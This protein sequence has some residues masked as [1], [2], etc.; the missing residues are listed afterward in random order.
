MHYLLAL[1][2]PY[3]PLQALTRRSWESLNALHQLLGRVVTLFFCLHTAFYLNFF[4]RANLLAKRIREADVIL[5]LFAITS[6]TIIGTTALTWVRRRNYRLFYAVHVVLATMLLPVL[7]FHVTHIRIYIWE[8]LAV[9]VLHFVFRVFNERTVAV[10]MALVPGTKDLL[11][12][13]IPLPSSSSSAGEGK[14]W[15][16]TWQPGQHVYLSLQRTGLWTRPI[17]SKNPFTIASLPTEDGTLKLVARMMDGNTAAL[18][19]EAGD[20]GASR[21]ASTSLTIEGPYGLTTHS[22]SLLGYSRVLFVAGGV[23]ATFIVPLYRCL[24]RDL[25]PSAGSRRRQNVKFVWAVREVSETTWAM[26]DDSGEAKG[27]RER[28]SVFVTRGTGAARMVGQSADRGDDEA[29]DAPGYVKTEGADDMEDGVEM[30][31]LLPSGDDDE[32]ISAV[33]D[34]K[35]VNVEMGRPDVRALVNETLAGLTDSDKVA[36]VVCGPRGLARSVRSEVGRWIEK[37][38]VWFW[39]EEFGL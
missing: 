9:Y 28:L 2:T 15:L 22:E 10:S 27:F 37:R 3:S 21:S 33:Q 11:A 12:I 17:R 13:E 19:K 5:G 32:T 38:E 29:E 8:T 1:K 6:F 20:V 26:P 4:V 23:G 7:Y 24:L 30:A 39:S 34:G 35:G 31:R 36:V 18:A 25:S 14:S 16:K